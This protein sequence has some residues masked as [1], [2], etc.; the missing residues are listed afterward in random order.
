MITLLVLLRSLFIY[1]LRVSWRHFAG[2]YTR[3]VQKRSQQNESMSGKETT[4]IPELSLDPDLSL[5]V[6]M[7]LF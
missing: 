4:L 6:T 1:R 2:Y 5:K 7:N 3:R